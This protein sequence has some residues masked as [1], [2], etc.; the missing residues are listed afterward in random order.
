MIRKLNP[1]DRIPDDRG[2]VTVI[3]PNAPMPERYVALDLETATYD[4][5]ICQVGIAIFEH[6]EK[7]AEASY[8]VKPP[9]NS[10]DPRC[11]GIHGITPDQ[12]KDSPEFPVVWPVIRSILDGQYIVAHNASFDLNVLDRSI[13]RFR[14]GDLVIQ[15]CIDTCRELGGISLYSACAFFGV[16]LARHHDALADATAAGELLAR[17]SSTPGVTVTIPRVKEPTR[18]TIS[19][20]NRRPGEDARS[21]TPFSGK[22]VVISGEFERFPFRDDL[23]KVLSTCGARVTSSVSSKTDFLIAG[24]G[25]GPSKLEKARDLQ[26]AGAPIL[27]MTE[28]QLYKLLDQLA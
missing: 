23:A 26:Q 9:R 17:Y 3:L 28:R 21:D 16:E 20:E 5:D 1:T 12:T 7:V 13:E 22:T 15:D 24:E 18:T 4:G 19:K 8:L 6:G 11:S 10:Y 14:L 2:S 25:V 27:L